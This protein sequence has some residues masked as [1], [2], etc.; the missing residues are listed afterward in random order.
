[1]KKQFEAIEKIVNILAELEPREASRV[2]EFAQ[3]ITW[4]RRGD[5][6]GQGVMAATPTPVDTPPKQQELP[7]EEKKEEKPKK[8]AAKKVAKK[9]K[10]PE[11]IP[12]F[13]EMIELCRETAERLKSGPKVKALI[14]KAC[15]VSALKDADTSTFPALVKLL[16][17]AK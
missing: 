10:A 11:V 14:E 2:M 3:D 12:T 13:E 16:K 8:K 1:M 7:L 6:H 5:T 17:A 4:E 15:S 9:T